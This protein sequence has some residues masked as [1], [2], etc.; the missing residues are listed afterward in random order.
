MLSPIECAKIGLLYFF[1]RYK[2]LISDNHG[3]IIQKLQD[4]F[5]GA[6]FGSCSC[7]FDIQWMF[8]CNQ[9]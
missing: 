6:F 4:M 1:N 3:M 5:S 9:K 8:K 7:K 2:F